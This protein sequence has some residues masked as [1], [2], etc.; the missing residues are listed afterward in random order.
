MVRDAQRLLVLSTTCQVGL[1]IK[2]TV[3]MRSEFQKRGAEYRSSDCGTK[4]GTRV[5]VVLI[6]E[7]LN[8]SVWFGSVAVRLYMKRTWFFLRLTCSSPGPLR[9]FSQGLP[10]ERLI[11]GDEKADIRG[12]ASSARI[13]S[14]RS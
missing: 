4:R 6:F 14:S 1:A 12:I 10:S 11:K 3:E 2:K 5:V 7:S 13:G 8:R 9:H